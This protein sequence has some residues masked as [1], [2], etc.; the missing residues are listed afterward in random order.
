VH[1]P[2]VVG[3]LSFFDEPSPGQA[4]GLPTVPPEEAKGMTSNAAAP[5]A[6]RWHTAGLIGLIVAV[7]AIGM[8]L[9][10]RETGVSV[11]QVARSRVLAVYLPMMLVQWSLELYVARVGRSRIALST[12]LGNRWHGMRRA[13]TDV[14]L[15]LAMVAILEAI[16]IVGARAFGG[17]NHGA[18]EALLPKTNGERAAWVL[19][20]ISVGFCEEL[21]YRG[22]LQ[23]QLSAFTGS[24]GLGV[25]LQ[26]MLFGLAHGEQ[27]MAAMAGAAIAGIALG[28]LAWARGS[29]IPGM[30]SHVFID[31]LG[32]LV[33]R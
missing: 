18:I 16:A 28:V 29:L 12:L 9:N 27:G 25:A 33:G 31:L 7:A 13:L 8:V 2:I 20:S 17:G 26:A 21:V 15:A 24:V 5:L 19:V 6:P 10:S 32:G 4:R 30:L 3:T 14:A 1:S 22:Y 11:S 23:T